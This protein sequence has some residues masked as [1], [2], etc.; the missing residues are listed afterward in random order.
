MNEEQLNAARLALDCVII[1]QRA[2]SEL[3][4]YLLTNSD[5]MPDEEIC[6]ILPAI[7]TPLMALRAIMHHDPRLALMMSGAMTASIEHA[8]AHPFQGVINLIRSEV[9]AV[10]ASK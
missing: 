10:E 1:A 8:K 9:R 3:V 6:R 5:P 2:C 4:S 7:E